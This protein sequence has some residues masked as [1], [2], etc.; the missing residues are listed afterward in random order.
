MR[1]AT[2]ASWCVSSRRR[3]RKQKSVNGK[4]QGKQKG[5]LVSRNENPHPATA[6][7]RFRQISMQRDSGKPPQKVEGGDGVR[8]SLFAL[9]DTNP[10]LEKAR[11]LQKERLD[12]TRADND[13]QDFE[14]GRTAG[15]GKTRSVE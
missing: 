13:K 12:E 10:G 7:T 11:D 2:T 6:P 14:N 5:S 3:S 15:L 1:I 9:A 4:W 8:F